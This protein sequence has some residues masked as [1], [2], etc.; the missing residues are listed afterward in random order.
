MR[1][2]ARGRS[3]VGRVKVAAE[4]RL[5]GKYV[6]STADPGLSVDDV[7]LG[8][9]QLAEVERA[10]RCLKSNLDLRPLY[11][12]LQQRLEAHVLLYSSA[13]PVPQRGRHLPAAA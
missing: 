12:C 10:V 11:H 4:A 6:V 1:T 9:K 8:Y 13:R 2:D 7:V 5:D 3:A